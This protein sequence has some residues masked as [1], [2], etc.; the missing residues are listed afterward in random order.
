MFDSANKIS[1]IYSTWKVNDLTDLRV[2]ECSSFNLFILHIHIYNEQLD[3]S[4]Y[5]NSTINFGT[6]VLYH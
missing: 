5:G 1:S 3:I 2:G 4:F 6:S